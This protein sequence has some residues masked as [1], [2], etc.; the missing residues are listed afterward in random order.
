M[1]AVRKVRQFHS[2]ISFRLETHNFYMQFPMNFEKYVSQFKYGKIL[3]H[4]AQRFHADSE[5]HPEID[6]IARFKLP[7]WFICQASSQ[8]TYLCLS[9]LLTAAY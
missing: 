7:W 8:A 3:L 9:A 2:R 1:V 4:Q 6:I 5:V